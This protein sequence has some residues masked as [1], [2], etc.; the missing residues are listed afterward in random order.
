MLLQQPLATVTPTVDGEVLA[1]LAHAER[2]FSSRALHRVIGRYSPEGVR[3]SLN[4]L[5]AQGIVT[6]EDA[7][8]AKLYRLNRSHLA[9]PH[10]IGLASMRDELLRRLRDRLATWA[11]AP[12]YAALFGSAARGDMSEDSDID[13]FVVRPRDVVLDEP[14][15]T[16][17][18]HALASDAVDWTGN[19]LRTFELGD[20]EVVAELDAGSG[21]VRAIHAEG[22]PLAGD[23]RY[24]DRRMRLADHV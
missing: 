1:A 4:R 13:L 18:V 5:V 23:H 22:I 9:A 24:L 8:P 17:Q 11:P 16:E 3:R 6:V 10:V 14:G 21:T 19:D 12:V 2:A 20:R 15:W 7:P